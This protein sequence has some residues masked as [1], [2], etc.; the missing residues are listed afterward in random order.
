[1]QSWPQRDPEKMKSIF[2]LSIQNNLQSILD[3]LVPL[4]R[5]LRKGVGSCWPDKDGEAMS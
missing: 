3:E 5:Q 1:M 4:E 2:K